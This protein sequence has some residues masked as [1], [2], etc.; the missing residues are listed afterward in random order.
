MSDWVDN[1]NDNHH[2]NALALLSIKMKILF[3][4]GLGPGALALHWSE[5]IKVFTT[6]TQPKFKIGHPLST[7]QD[8][9]HRL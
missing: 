2:A 6:K 4:I 5:T 3:L 1:H 9:T 8:H 7:S